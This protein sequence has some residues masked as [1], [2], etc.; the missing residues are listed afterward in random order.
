MRRSSGSVR[1]PMMMLLWGIAALFL[2]KTLYATAVDIKGLLLRNQPLE[3]A[4]TILTIGALVRIVL[5]VRKQKGSCDYED[6]SAAGFPAPLE[7]W[8][9]ERA[10]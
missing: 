10:F 1:L 5:A 8:R 2:R 4:L 7:M 6:Y 9:P 3:L